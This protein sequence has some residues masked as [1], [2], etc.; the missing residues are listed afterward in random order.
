MDSEKADCILTD[1][2]YEI[3]IDYKNINKNLEN[4]HV[5]IFNNDRALIKQ[6]N[7]SPLN[8]KKF[9]VFNHSACAIPQEGGNECFLDHILISHETKGKPK[10]RFNKGMGLRTV[11]KGEYRRSKNH[12]HEKP[13]NLLGDLIKS[14]TVEKD[15]ILDMFGGSG[16]ILMVSEQLGRTCYT[17]E[18]DPRYIDL[19]VRRYKDYKGEELEIKLI[20]G[21]KEYSF[22]D[23]FKEG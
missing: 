21:G 6:L 3:E 11:I 20:R 1:P 10:T 18:L 22:N 15:I 17:V 23:I 7:N 19:I 5:F 13:V 12:K 9:F 14:Y 8:F 2:P 4:G 16:A